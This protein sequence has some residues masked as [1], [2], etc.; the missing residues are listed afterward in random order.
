MLQ[1]VSLLVESAE[2][3]LALLGQSSLNHFIYCE[4]ALPMLYQLLHQLKDATSDGFDCEQDEITFFKFTKPK[5]LSQLLYCN[6]ILHIEAYC[7]DADARK[8]KHF[9]KNQLKTINQLLDGQKEL[10]RYLDNSCTHN[11]HFYFLRKNCT[12]FS[13]VT[14]NYLGS[15][16]FNTSHDFSVAQI[17]SNRKLKAYLME[18]LACSYLPTVTKSKTLQWTGSKAA[19]TEL[20]Y[21][22][23][24]SKTFE[25]G[26]ANLNQI[27]QCLS[28]AFGVDL[29]HISRTYIE[30]RQRK[31]DR[32]AFLEE[33]KTLLLR[34][35]DE[36]DEHS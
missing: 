22:L 15:A 5:Y 18:L 17:L 9:L 21:G 16:A 35:M 10:C 30:L 8:R 13:L 11:D 25:N 12:G 32:C 29:T 27:A 23:Y 28:V 20:A 31:G 1:N 7:P 36:A 26:T 33:M 24:C 34:R 6:A 19:L 2:N 14:E 3:S 4:E